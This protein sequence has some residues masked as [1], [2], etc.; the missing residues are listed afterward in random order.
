MVTIR[1]ILLVMYILFKETAK[2]MEEPRRT[3]II[4]Q[5]YKTRR[6]V[7]VTIRVILLV[8]NI[9]MTQ[10]NIVVLLEVVSNSIFFMISDLYPLI[11][12][13]KMKR[14]KKVVRK[15]LRCCTHVL[16]VNKTVEM[17]QT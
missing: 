8:M 12:S 3:D 10:L 2:I 17:F 9:F 7:L 5:D 4:K 13:F 1:V 15:T 14:F 11:N 16:C 6:Y